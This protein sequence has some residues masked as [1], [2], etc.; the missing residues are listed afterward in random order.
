M[1]REAWS[2]AVHGVAKSRARLSDWTDWAS[3]QQQPSFSLNLWE[4]WND[5]DAFN[6]QFSHW[7]SP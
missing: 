3:K 1:D 4:G 5:P 7:F 6:Q 2:A